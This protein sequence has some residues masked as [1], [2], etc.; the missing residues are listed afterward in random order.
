MLPLASPLRTP[1]TDIPP[2]FAVPAT[3]TSCQGRGCVVCGYRETAPAEWFRLR[4][5]HFFLSCQRAK[6]SGATHYLKQAG[7][8]EAERKRE[9]NSL[10]RKL[11]LQKSKTVNK[12]L[13]QAPW[14][15]TKITMRMG[16]G[17][18]LDKGITRK[19]LALFHCHRPPAVLRDKR[20]SGR[21]PVI[22]WK[23]LRTIH[24]CSCQEY[25]RR[26]VEFTK[27]GPRGCIEICV[28]IVEGHDK[29]SGRKRFA[30]SIRTKQCAKRNWLPT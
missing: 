19:L 21:P 30:R 17:A 10:H 9:G 1:S 28:P 13:L 11:Q 3:Q 6:D 29:A 2:Q 18:Y 4:V 22:K 5:D 23:R 25:R 12:I 27:N 7:I 26:N 15:T 16:V 20:G 8:D 14:I 24:V